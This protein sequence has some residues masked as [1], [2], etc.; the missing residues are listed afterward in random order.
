MAEAEV[1]HPAL[2]GAPW[3]VIG[4]RVRREERRPRSASWRPAQWTVREDVL[5]PCTWPEL[6]G[7]AE[8]AVGRSRA[9]VYVRDLGGA[10]PDR[11]MV[12]CLRGAAGA[13]RVEGPLAPFAEVL[14]AR[15][16]AAVLR[17]AAVHREAGRQA[18]AQ[19]WRARARR[20][21]KDGRAARRGGSVRAT[22]G[23][24]PTL[25]GRH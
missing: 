4:V 12:L 6:E 18:E 17:A 19:V 5:L 10:E 23:G 2:A 16:R 1:G 22:S 25:G 7:L 8:I 20:I 15:V 3:P 21:L 24:L 13:V 14:A 9:R 11:R